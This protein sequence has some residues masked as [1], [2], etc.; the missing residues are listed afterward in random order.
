MTKKKTKDDGSW[1]KLIR[2]IAVILLLVLAIHSCVAKPFYIPSDSMMPILRNGD[3]LIVSKYPYG[4]SYASVSFHLAPKM[5]GRLFGRLPERG[6]IVV[7]EH[8]LTRV[9]YIKRVIGLPGD[10]IQLTNGELSINGKP[11]K[12]E[13]QPM[14]AIPVDRNTPGPDSSLSRFVTRGADGKELL[15]IPIVRETLPGGASFDTI[16]MGPGY[17][18]DDYGPYVVPANHLFLMGDNRDG[19]ADSR[20]PAELKGLGGAVPFDAI[21]GRAEIISF[22]TDG[23]AKWYNPLSWFEA[24]R[25]GRAGTDLRPVRAGD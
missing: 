19:S 2:D 20:V 7:L 24:L 1:G 6:D 9:D 3:R 14:L 21:A 18:T 22:S 12:R 4:W 17:A 11:V 13:V 23:T 10:T 8:P 15:E 16:D 5:E 25:P